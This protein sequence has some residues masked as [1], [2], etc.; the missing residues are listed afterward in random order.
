MSIGYFFGEL[1]GVILLGFGFRNRF[2]LN[3]EIGDILIY[4]GGAV[5]MI[6]LFLAINLNLFIFTLIIGIY[7]VY[8]GKRIAFKYLGLED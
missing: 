1:L 7:I 6:F 3:K 5:F 4:L 8:G 2:F